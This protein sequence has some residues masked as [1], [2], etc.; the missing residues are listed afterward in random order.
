MNKERIIE[1]NNKA[2]TKNDERQQVEPARQNTTS[3]VVVHEQTK[4]RIPIPTIIVGTRVRRE[5]GDLTSLKASMKALGL[6][7]PVGVVPR[8]TPNA[9]DLVTGN[10]RLAAAQQL[11]WTEIDARVLT[12]VDDLM[13]LQAERDE[14][15]ERLE[16][17]LSEKA[18]LAG[19]IAP[20]EEAAAK[21]RQR[22]GKGSGKLT[23]GQKG[24][25]KDKIAKAVGLSR[26]TLEKA[27]EVVEAA[28]AD[29]QQFADLQKEMDRTGKV[30]KPHAKLRKAKQKDT[31]PVTPVDQ[32]LASDAEIIA[33]A[34]KSFIELSGI[35]TKRS[36]QPLSETAHQKLAGFR[37]LINR[38]LGGKEGMQ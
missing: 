4:L 2:T 24:E 12:T 10:R 11:G 32:S 15:V 9:Y 14:N 33:F 16:L 27:Q 17:T 38:I 19:Q 8:V 30:S 6:L 23:E 21:T 37:D 18:A 1:M 36:G 7:H 29:P 26:H 22:A 25:A 34:E 28:K 35:D 31:T 20:L 3:S 5:V 13:R